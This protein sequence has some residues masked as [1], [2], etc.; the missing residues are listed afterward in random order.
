MCWA[1]RRVWRQHFGLTASPNPLRQPPSCGLHK[2]GILPKSEH[3]P[4]HKDPIQGLVLAPQ[5][6]RLC[7]TAAETGI[8]RPKSSLPTRVRRWE[9]LCPDSW[10]ANRPLIFRKLLFNE[11]VSLV[12]SGGWQKWPQNCNS[13][14]KR[15]LFT[16]LTKE[17]NTT[18]TDRRTKMTLKRVVWVAEANFILK[19]DIRRP[20]SK[21]DHI[22]EG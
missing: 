1:E 19:D 13:Y 16:G 9:L 3:G 5:Q 21:Y 20:Q 4:R 6:A 12:R 10:A 14:L 8:S 7:H 22:K 2:T 17:R 18:D 11:K 15:H